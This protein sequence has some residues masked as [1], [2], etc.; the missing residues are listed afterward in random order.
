MSIQKFISLFKSP[1]SKKSQSFKM[2]EDTYEKN[3][4]AF[5]YGTEVSV[6]KN[7][8]KIINGIFTSFTRSTFT[9]TD[10]DGK[11]HKFNNNDENIKIKIIKKNKSKN[12]HPKGG[13]TQNKRKNQNKTKKN[14]K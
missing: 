4:D 10:K 7:D 13:K 6:K 3:K 14:T 9:I 8:D 12:Y 11:E 5:V 1:S 2:F